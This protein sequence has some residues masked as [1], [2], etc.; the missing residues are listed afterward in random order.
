M[1]RGFD[2]GPDGGRGAAPGGQQFVDAYGRPVDAYGRLVDSYG[3][4]IDTYGHLVDAYGRPVDQYGNPVDDE[5][6]PRAEAPAAGPRRRRRRLITPTRVTLFIALVGS[7]AFLLYAVTVRDTSQIPLLASGLAVLGI[8]FSALALSGA[9]GAMSAGR[10]GSG[11]R[12]FAMA[13][14]GGIASVIAFGC[15][16]AAIVLAMVWRP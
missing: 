13:L 9:R 1:A 15:F 11:G 4:L 14:S 6:G 8:V 12:A 3:R 16:G 7:V 10:D 5:V 2:S